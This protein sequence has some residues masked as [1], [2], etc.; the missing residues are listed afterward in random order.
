MD[1]PGLK[2]LVEV[3]TIRNNGTESTRA[4]PDT[5]QAVVKEPQS[6]LGTGYD[7]TLGN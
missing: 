1:W 4:T 3:V 5:M 6:N 2:S 7:P